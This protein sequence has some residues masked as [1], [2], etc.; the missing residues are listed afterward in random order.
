MQFTFV[1][2]REI[3]IKTNRGYKLEQWIYNDTLVNKVHL[4]FRNLH[5]P[6]SVSKR[7]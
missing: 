7:S 1:T 4:P 5:L 6:P 3:D 2:E